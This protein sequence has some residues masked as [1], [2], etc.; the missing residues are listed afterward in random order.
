M[1][2]GLTPSA[3]TSALPRGE[4]IDTSISSASSQVAKARGP[5]VRSS[6]RSPRETTGVGTG[7]IGRLRPWAASTVRMISAWLSVSG[8][9]SS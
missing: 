9:A 6:V 4:S 1:R 3:S 7:R 8:P 2:C 5:I